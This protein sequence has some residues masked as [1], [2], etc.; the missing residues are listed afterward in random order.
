ML[1]NCVALTKVIDLVC[2]LYEMI[3]IS[4]CVGMRIVELKRISATPHRFYVKSRKNLL[5]AMQLS[6]ERYRKIRQ[7]KFFTNES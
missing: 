3:F 6:R 7:N 2:S 5:F 4:T 1:E